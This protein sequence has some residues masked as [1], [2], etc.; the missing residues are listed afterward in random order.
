M[1]DSEA[2]K[3]LETLKAEYDSLRYDYFELKFVVLEFGKELGYNISIPPK[4]SYIY[5][6]K[7]RKNLS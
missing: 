6:E 3:S 2:R 5:V 4:Q 7:E 1:K